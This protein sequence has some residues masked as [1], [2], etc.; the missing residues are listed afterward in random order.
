MKFFK[1]ALAVGFSFLFFLTAN[2]SYGQEKLFYVVIGAFSYEANAERFLQI[3]EK[4][5]L[6][7]VIRFK[8]DRNL[9]YVY[10]IASETRGP[11]LATLNTVKALG[12]YHDAWI[13]HGNLDEEEMESIAKVDRPTQ[14][15]PTEIPNDNQEEAGTSTE[16]VVETPNEGEAKIEEVIPTSHTYYFNTTNMT[17]GKEVKGKISVIDP[18]SNKVVG[19]FP[20]HELVEIP[21][22]NNDSGMHKFASSIFGFREIQYNID[23]FNPDQSGLKQIRS[24]DNQ[25]VIDFELQR[26][27]KGDIITLYKVYFFRDAA[28]MR[29]ESSYE[30]EALLDMVRENPDLKIKIHG[31][32]NGNSRGRIIE[33][34]DEFKDLFNVGGSTKISNGSAKKLS[35]LRARTIRNYLINEGVEE[36][37]TKIKGWGGRKMLYDKN[38]PMADNNIRVEIEITD[39]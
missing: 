13:Y 21:A 31:H 3:I 19:E 15:K 10:V 5:D 35:Y 24:E 32:T 17:T 20:S 4:D 34:E 22:P 23:P 11:A 26:Y 1:L 2:T 9:H 7:G 8:K 14:P 28:M 39:E 12:K 37:R 36:E 27:R 38:D 16:G 29:P 25:L 33:P 18:E 30:L 6:Q